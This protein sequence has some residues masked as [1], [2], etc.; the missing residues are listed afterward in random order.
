MATNKKQKTELS[1]RE[2]ARQLASKQNSSD[3]KSSLW[4]RLGIVVVIAAISLI[5]LSRENVGSYT[6]GEAPA[7]ATAYGGVALASDTEVI[8]QNEIDEIDAEDI[9]ANI[10]SPHSVDTVE[11]TD[12]PKVTIYTDPA[13]SH[14]ATFEDQYHDFLA[15]KLENEEIILEYRTVA[16]MDSS[17]GGYSS[18]AGNAFMC[19]A[20][21][22]PEHYLDYVGTVTAGGESMTADD[23]VDYGQENYDID[24]SEC[25]DN[26]TYRALVSY[27]TN[28]ATQANV[29]GTPTILIN[30]TDWQNS[31]L[32]FTEQVE[33][34][35]ATGNVEGEENADSTNSDDAD[36]DDDNADSV[37]EDIIRQQSES[38]EEAT[39]EENTEQ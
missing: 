39:E 7:E 28:L 32:D 4:I 23:L 21:E 2:R 15:E 10:I 3:E 13:C 34:A 30:E 19:V 33:N 9:P 1:A 22:Y 8:E 29:S 27:A 36:S 31:D 5:A 11:E 6:A 20:S 25:V 14:C 26:N 17:S 16:Y 35:I 37:D 24:I 38:G 12:K 18:R